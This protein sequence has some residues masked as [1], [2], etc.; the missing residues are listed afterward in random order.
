MHFVIGGY[1]RVGRFLAHQLEADGHTVAIIDRDW[2][3]LQELDDIRGRKFTGEVFDRETLEAAGIAEADCYV[4]VTSG[5]NSNVVSARIAKETFE[6]PNVLARIYDPRRAELY[7][8]LGIWTVAS[9]EW[10]GAR[11]LRMMTNPGMV[12]EYQFGGGEVEMIEVV[13][14]ASMAG[15]TLDSLE[16]L[17]ESRVVALVREHRAFV[18][19]PH[20][21]VAEGDRLYV[22]VHKGMV[23]RF[24]SDLGL[25]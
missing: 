22:V 17:G 6:V 5:D 15:R 13:A 14:P 11:L 9:V 4:A 8:D 24:K 7:R 1:G 10:A 23:D 25:E 12:S 21:E 18:G 16:H 2:R 19:Q 20:V 3:A